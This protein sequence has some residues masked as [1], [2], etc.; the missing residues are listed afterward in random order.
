MKILLF[1]VIFAA[2]LLSA[3]VSAFAQDRGFT[4]CTVVDQTGTPLNV[5]S[6]PNGKRIVSKLKS[7]TSLYLDKYGDDA[8][9]R[10]WALVRLTGKKVNKPLGWV[11]SEFIEC[12]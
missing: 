11:L 9:G 8:Q 4:R 3:H 10:E 6:S 2:V 12:E 5:R 1:T 7:G